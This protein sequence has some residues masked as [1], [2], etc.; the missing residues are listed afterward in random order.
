VRQGASGGADGGATRVDNG[1]R[2][3]PAYVSA[4]QSVEHAV[5]FW[6]IG[7]ECGGERVGGGGDCGGGAQGAIEARQGFALDRGGD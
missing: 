2:G 3:Q 5:A 1:D 7:K 4:G 6:A